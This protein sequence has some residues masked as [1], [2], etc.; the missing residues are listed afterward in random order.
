MLKGKLHQI[1]QNKRIN[2]IKGVTYLENGTNIYT[3]SGKGP[4]QSYYI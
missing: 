1:K 2:N 4:I 3:K